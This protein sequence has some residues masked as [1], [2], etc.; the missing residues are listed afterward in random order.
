MGVSGG[1]ESEG[2][3]LPNLNGD[4]EDACAASC[5]RPGVVMVADDSCDDELIVLAAAAAA[6]GLERFPIRTE[7]GDELAS[8]MTSPVRSDRDW[9]SG[10]LTLS[11]AS[12]RTWSLGSSMNTPPPV[13][14]SSSQPILASRVEISSWPE[15]P[16]TNVDD[17]ELLTVP[18]R[19]GAG[20]GG[21]SCDDETMTNSSSS[22]ESSAG[23]D[24]GAGADGADFLPK[25]RKS[26]LLSILRKLK[27]VLRGLWP[28]ALVSAALTDA[29]AAACACVNTG[30]ATAASPLGGDGA[31]QLPMEGSG[32]RVGSGWIG[33]RLA[34]LVEDAAEVTA[35]FRLLAVPLEVVVA[36]MVAGPRSTGVVVRLWRLRRTFQ[37][38]DR[39]LSGRGSRTE[40]GCSEFA[41]ST[42]PA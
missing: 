41:T 6:A 37:G 14:W 19:T 39:Q 3:K 12:A 42:S 7:S 5:G 2:E 21:G 1:G 8:S 17:D 33:R 25:L 4:E 38:V 36:G 13:I 29:V 26:S 18:G 10:T 31:S 9:P 24:A 40:R 11:R 23:A 35:A 28:V 16:P 22:G 15:P 20:V 32:G 34:P 27:L 30:C